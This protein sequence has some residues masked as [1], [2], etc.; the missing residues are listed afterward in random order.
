MS[1]SLFT[2]T[3]FNLTEIFYL[4]ENCLQLNNFDKILVTASTRDN[5]IIAV[6]Y[7]KIDYYK[8]NVSKSHLLEKTTRKWCIFNR[9]FTT[10]QKIVSQRP[11]QR[12]QINFILYTKK[13]HFYTKNGFCI[14]HFVH[15]KEKLYTETIF[16]TMSIVQDL[17]KVYTIFYVIERIERIFLYEDV[18]SDFI[19]QLKFDYKST[20]SRRRTNKLKKTNSKFFSKT[21][22]PTYN[23]IDH[24][25]GQTN[26]IFF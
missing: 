7:S 12:A 21:T 24:I 20:K 25:C 19:S 2:K 15:E 14:S 4:Y 22:W 1:K 26:S 23:V 16:C 8:M 11:T 5:S 13:K 3:T 17:C 9:L 18:N 10:D 6:S